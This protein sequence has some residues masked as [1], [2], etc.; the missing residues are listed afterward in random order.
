MGSIKSIMVK[1]YNFEKY[2]DCLL[3]IVPI[4]IAALAAMTVYRIFFF[5]YFADFGSLKGLYG[6]VF[7]SFFLGLRFDLSVL[8]YINS[9]VILIFTFFLFLRNLRIFRFFTGLIKFYY[10][11]VFTAVVILNLIDFGFFTYFNDHI[12]LLF[13]QFFEDDMF[14]LLKTIAYDWRFPIAL[15]VLAAASYVIYKFSSYTR[16]LLFNMKCAIA[17]SFWSF[18]LK[19][20]IVLIVP[21]IVFLAAR[22]TVSMFPLGTFY[23][24]ISPNSFI[25]KLSISSLHSLA[26]ALYAKSEQSGDKIKL[27][28]KFGLDGNLLDLSVFNKITPASHDIAMLKPN[29]VFIILESFG[30]AP[31]LYNGE[32]F[33]VLGGLKKH[34]DDDTVLYNFLSAGR[35]TVHCLEST[36]L[37]MPQRPFSLQITQ[38]PSAY[39]RYSSAAASPYQKAGYDTKAIYG[40][41]LMW[42]GIE[43]F[44]KAQGFNKTYGEG[45]IKNEY[46]HQWGINDAQFFEI[47]LRELNETPNRPKLIYAMSTGTHPPYEVPPYYKPLP[48][49]IPAEL[50]RM[51]PGEKKYGKKIFETYQFANH[52]AAKFLDAVKNSKLAENTIVVITGDH[53]LREINPPLKEDLFKKYAV[54]MYIYMPEKIKKRFNAD[55]AGSHIDIMPTLYDL[56]LSETEYVAAGTSLLDDSKK[57]IAFNSEGFILSQDKAVLYNID[58]GKAEYFNFDARTKT[59]TETEYTQ[60][61]G[62]MVEYYKNT[63]AAADIFLKTE[64]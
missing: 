64:K 45:S 12:N 58:A 22:G 1:E 39:N 40:G 25:N 18:P 15:A 19:T 3:K 17:S 49:N 55:I 16:R 13:F 61:H 23:T 38:S 63:V 28:E 41:S 51:M 21:C 53:N 26:D 52:E 9:V 36:V 20:V 5:F 37:N 29:V 47:I 7:K 2:F 33:N 24:Q 43:N 14:A 4:N 34:F 31:I 44:F 54:P 27:Y 42:R 57:H 48:L 59:L 6:Y 60:R 62:E 56:S 8:A 30:E 46:R 10:W 35:I 11:F 50:A 32:D